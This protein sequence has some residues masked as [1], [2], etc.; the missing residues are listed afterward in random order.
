MKDNPQL[1]EA[2][3]KALVDIKYKQ[4]VELDKTGVHHDFSDALNPLTKAKHFNYPIT[5][6]EIEAGKRRL[7]KCDKIKTKEIKKEHKNDRAFKN[8]VEIKAVIDYAFDSEKFPLENIKDE[9]NPFIEWVRSKRDNC[10]ATRSGMKRSTGKLIRNFV[11]ETMMSEKQQKAFWKCQGKNELI[12][13]SNFLDAIYSVDFAFRPY[14]FNREQFIDGKLYV[15]I[16]EL[17]TVILNS[18]KKHYSILKHEEKSVG[19]AS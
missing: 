5:D 7:K 15:N 12:R 1:G 6:Q 19:N 10:H 8:A 16:K 9:W 13:H 3:L 2:E 14:L 11:Y 4:M 17:G 18:S